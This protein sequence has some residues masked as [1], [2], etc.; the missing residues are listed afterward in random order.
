[1]KSSVLSQA[2][3]FLVLG[4]FALVVF[5][6]IWFIKSRSTARLSVEDKVN[7]SALANRICKAAASSNC[8]IA[9]GGKEKGFG[10]IVGQAGRPVA[11]REQVRGI[12]SVQQW[13][14]QETPSGWVFSNGK[15]SITYAAG[16]GSIV[17]TPL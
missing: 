11:S 9:W 16:S 7:I 5:A 14:E 1:M 13:P 15:Y 10:E 4:A 12:L 2:R 6:A 17:I 3:V 8:Q